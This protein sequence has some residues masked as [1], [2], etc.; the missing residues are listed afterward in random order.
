M[1]DQVLNTFTRYQSNFLM[2][3]LFDMKEDMIILPLSPQGERKL[4]MGLGWPLTVLSQYEEKSLGPQLLK[5]YEAFRTLFKAL[6]SQMHILEL[7]KHLRRGVSAKIV[8]VTVN[9]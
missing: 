4:I 9:C 3:F 2:I 5:N 6:N 8:F 1:F 7:A